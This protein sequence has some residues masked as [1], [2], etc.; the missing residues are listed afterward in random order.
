MQT[1]E[2]GIGGAPTRASTFPEDA[3]GRKAHPVVSGV[4]DYFPDAIVAIAHV[5]FTGNEQHNA[6]QPL[7][8]AR[9]KS[10]DEADALLRH[11]LQRGSNDSDGL[12]HS[13]KMAWRALALL[14]KEIE[15]EKEQELQRFIQLE[16]DRSFQQALEIISPS[17]KK[18]FPHNAGECVDQVVRGSSYKKDESLGPVKCDCE[19]SRIP[20]QKNVLPKHT[21]CKFDPMDS[22]PITRDLHPE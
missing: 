19:E 20:C 1:P 14:Q 17:S 2:I 4:L 12:R 15:A 11:L 6:G 3:K 13:A 10:S 21:E 22:C 7:H 18:V 9:G 5:S 16:R 8:W